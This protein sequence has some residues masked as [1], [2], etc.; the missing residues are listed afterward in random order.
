MAQ[1]GLCGR[2]GACGWFLGSRWP[3]V[4]RLKTLQRVFIYLFMPLSAFL[5]EEWL[6][7]LPGAWSDRSLH[8]GLAQGCWRGLGMGR[9]CP[10]HWSSNRPRAEP[11]GFQVQGLRLVQGDVCSE[12]HPG[13]QKG[14][15]SRQ[16]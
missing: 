4:S 9:Q 12:A 13:V 16:T 5:L 10:L 14:S 1:G 3:T 15:L 6:A 8:T 11:A 7:Y 2:V